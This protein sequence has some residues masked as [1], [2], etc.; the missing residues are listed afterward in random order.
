[1]KKNNVSRRVFLERAAV[2]MGL[3]VAGLSGRAAGALPEPTSAK[4]PPWRGVNLL[5]KFMAPQNGR[6]LET[7]FAWMVELGF[8]FARLP[9]DY[10]CWIDGNDWTKFREDALKE[11]DEAVALGEKYGVHILL[12]FHRA[13]GY[14][15]A[16]PREAK[17]LWKDEEAQQVCALHWGRFAERYKDIPNTRLSFNLFNEPA[18]MGA[19]PYRRVVAR[20]V[21]AIRKHDEKRLIV[22]DGRQWGHTPP[23]EL[24]GL[25]VAAA[26][27][28]YEP[29]HLTHYKATWV[30]GAEAFPLPTYPIHEGKTV[31]DKDAM[32]TRLIAPWKALEAKGMG[33]MVGEFGAYSKTP[34]AVVLSWMRDCIDL[35]K[36]A[37]WGWAMWNFRGSFGVLDSEREDVVYEDFHGHK[38]D[39]AML[40]VLKA[41]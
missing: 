40:D 33:V 7:D 13:P 14:T 2:A 17:E 3:G 41:G 36:E 35:W 31:W 19:A 5:E 10:R 25:G 30:K 39:R 26:T 4:L 16:E 27:R 15:V 28:G 20:M 12:N 8:N 1:M 24:L 38:L 37:G 32:R 22:C 29:F 34:H 11:I 23:E 21:E 6:F 9:L 18:M